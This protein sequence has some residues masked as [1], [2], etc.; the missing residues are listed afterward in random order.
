[1]VLSPSVRYVAP[2]A[3]FLAWLALRSAVPLSPL[4]EQVACLAVMIAVLLAVARPVIDLRV[5][6]VYSKWV[7]LAHDI[8]VN[9]RAE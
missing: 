8:R 5:R 6:N 1:M 2:F 4:V 3:T 9:R 7:N